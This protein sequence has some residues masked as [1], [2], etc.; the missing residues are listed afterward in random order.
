MTLTARP[1]EIDPVDNLVRL[2]IL[3]GHFEKARVTAAGRGCLI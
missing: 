3:P 2:W 1:G